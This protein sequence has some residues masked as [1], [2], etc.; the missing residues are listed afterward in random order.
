MQLNR[1]G[2]FLPCEA[3]DAA[4]LSQ[5]KDDNEAGREKDKLDSANLSNREYNIGNN[6]KRLYVTTYRLVKKKERIK[7]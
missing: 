7:Y 6:E 4:L 1:A 2:F 5:G 3:E